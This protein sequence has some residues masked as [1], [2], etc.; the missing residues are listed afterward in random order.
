MF[1][2]GLDIDLELFRRA[3]NRSI[4][5]G[6]TTTVIPLV[7]LAPRL[8]SCSATRYQR[9]LALVIG[10]LLASHT[11]LALPSLDRLGV[12]GAWSQ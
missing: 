6:I 8:V 12:Q 3:R 5:F 2:A 7:R 1:F 9:F 11:L 4:T 10:S